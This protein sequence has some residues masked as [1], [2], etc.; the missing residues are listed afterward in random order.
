MTLWNKLIVKGNLILGK[1]RLCF[2]ESAFLLETGGPSVGSGEDQDWLL[3]EAQDVRSWK[4]QMCSQEPTGRG[5]CSK[6]G[7]PKMGS[8]IDL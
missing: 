6:G 4:K 7:D 1:V 5:H 8:L 3:T 2:Y